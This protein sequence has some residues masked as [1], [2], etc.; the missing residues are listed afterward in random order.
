MRIGALHREGIHPAYLNSLLQTRARRADGSSSYNAKP[1]TSELTP[2]LDHSEISLIEN[3]QSLPEARR[4]FDFGIEKAKF[5]EDVITLFGDIKFNKVHD[6]TDEPVDLTRRTMEAG[7]TNLANVVVK[8]HTS[9]ELKFLK[10]KTAECALEDLGLVQKGNET[11]QMRD[12]YF[13]PTINGPIKLVDLGERYDAVV[14]KDIIAFK[15]EL[16]QIKATVAGIPRLKVAA[17]A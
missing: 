13:S 4:V 6:S 8:A 16:A 11:T 14:R 2:L 17:V 15:A 12:F 5:Y 7:I 3:T 10:E 9:G 1:S